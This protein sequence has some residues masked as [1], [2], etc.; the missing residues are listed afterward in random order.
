M[1]RR[2]GAESTYV[3][4]QQWSIRVAM[5]CQEQVWRALLRSTYARTHVGATVRPVW[6]NAMVG[7]FG[8]GMHV[9]VGR[10]KRDTEHK[11]P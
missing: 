3:Q 11:P 1:C 5:A 9:L 8:L 4:Q 10:G 7:V 2:M 6:R